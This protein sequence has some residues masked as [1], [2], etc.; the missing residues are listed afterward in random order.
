MTNP[1][2]HLLHKR[3]L[4]VFLRI[5]ISFLGFFLV[6]YFSLLLGFNYFGEKFLRKYLK[7]QITIKSEGLYNVDFNKLNLNI[8]TGKMIIREFSM[9]PDTALYR[10]MK[11]KGTISK[12][13]YQV[14]FKSLSIDHLN[15]FQIWSSRRIKLNEVV[16]EEPVVSIVGFPDTA[17]AR[18][19]R[20]RIIY[21]DIYPAVSRVCND[22][23]VDRVTVKNGLLLTSFRQKTGRLSLGEYEFSTV[24]Y[25]VSVNPFSYYN[26]ER[27]FYSRDIDFFVHN[28]EV[29]LGDSL[30]F[31]RA[32]QLGFSLN[33]SRLWGKQISLV[34]NF[35]SSRLK[36]AITGDFF[37]IEVPDFSIEG[38]DL[39]KALV[40]KEAEI[41][42]IDLENIR[43]KIFRNIKPIRDV[44]TIRRKIKLQT[45]NIY[46]II[47]G[48]LKSIAVDTFSIK[49]ASFEYFR[50]LYDLNPE[51]RIASA[52]LD[53]YHFFLDSLAHLDQN[54]IY[55]S[56]DAEL[57]LKNVS[58]KLRD[59]VHYMNSE[60]ILISTKRS[61]I[62]INNSILFPDKKLNLQSGR[63][64]NMISCLLPDL[65]FYDVDLKQVF[66]RRI[67]DFDRLE[68]SEPDITYTKYRKSRNPD[69]RFKSPENF[70]QE[71][72]EEV[73]YD[74]L[75]KYI[76]KIK[77]NSIHISHGQIRFL[78]QYEKME[79]KVFSGNFDLIMQDFIMDSI[80]GMNREGYFYSRDFTLDANELLFESPDSSRHL[81][82]DRLHVN[83][84]DSLI[85]IFDFSYNKLNNPRFIES[86]ITK[87]SSV[88]YDF[89][90]D[91][92]RVTGL[93]HKKLFLEK[94]LKAKTIVLKKP[95]LWLEKEE[96]SYPDRAPRET[97]S[98]GTSAF[99][100][101]FEIGKF[102]VQGG[103]FTYDGLD[104]QKVRYFSMDDLDFGIINAVI[105]IPERGKPD[106][107]IRFDSLQLTV[108]PVQIILADSTY[109][110]R[111]EKLRVHSYP[112]D[113]IAENIRVVPHKN[114]NND[115]KQYSLNTLVLPSLTMKGFYF[116]KAIFSNQWEMDEIRI[117]EPALVMEVRP[118]ERND[119][120]SK[121]LLQFQKIKLPPFMK[122]LDVG[123]IKMKNGSF[124]LK[125]TKRN[126]TRSYSLSNIDLI[127]DGLRIDSAAQGNRQTASLFF[128]RDV[129]FSCGG[130][131]WIT[132]DSMYT[133]SFAG[134]GFSSGARQAYVDSFTMVPN[135]SK[136]DF[137]RKI[138]HQTD[139]FVVSVPRI[140]WD[141]LDFEKLFHDQD[142]YSRRMTME[143]MT[144][145]A[146]RDKRV[147][148]PESQRPPMPARMVKMIGI[149]VTIDTVVITGG[150]VVYEEQTGEE[151][152]KVLFDRMDATLV[153]LTTDTLR[154]GQPMVFHGTSYLMGKAFFD[155]RFT[156]P[157]NT[158]NDTFSVVAY[159]NEAN[160][161]DFN[162]L[163]SKL[164]PFK[165]RSGTVTKT[166]IKQLYA[167]NNYSRGSMQMDYQN[168]NIEIQNTK[169]GLWNRWE[170]G[171][172]TLLI[173]WL[174][175]DSNPKKNGKIRVGYISYERD[176]S[177]GFFNFVWKSILSGIK[178]SLGYNSQEQ[179]EIK[180][181]DRKNQK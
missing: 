38:V 157:L 58:M 48:A 20:I 77:G 49:N 26:R 21:E 103:A 159:V 56:D 104:E 83:T 172:E 69:P 53:L 147:V 118:E 120:Q 125:L 160:L 54:K 31:L 158:P 52:N 6:V 117:E 28:L 170:T 173:N 96:K 15:F 177:K 42:D 140:Q 30:Y 45:A 151:P 111:C 154:Q 51:I 14:Y 8:L 162:P 150:G 155:A 95:G 84:E 17:T 119:N 88:V 179:K 166:E 89:T 163:V 41:K 55:Y 100:R 34:P 136:F 74:L 73:V 168:I 57:Q 146:Y 113:I 102:T 130:Q 76:E 19:S 18:R 65:V 80:H 24:L 78:R 126:T 68:I 61:L 33:K 161:T 81:E 174:I 129:T 112:A 94:I 110:L 164:L 1:E 175:P 167:N 107:L 72:N 131:K 109:V 180:K 181:A 90:F 62:N 122:S 75:Q 79:K 86:R 121:D 12:A 11:D 141:Y 10:K 134:F 16:F 59:E 46:T 137:S 71:E 139:R 92:L 114:S 50:N 5:L 47:A 108:F 152:G 40:G 60:E 123:K 4:S 93:N 116:D 143:R 64:I 171:L 142:I 87:R 27:V 144:I 97:I 133:Y 135:F 23:H 37:Q 13:L 32:D 29:S 178:S 153:N 101:S 66:N 128:C 25:D 148:F 39:Y 132:N 169:P 165:I 63:P 70:F 67:I 35:N 9:L 106:G 99:P 2:N 138:G 176:K 3:R 43:F 36:S 127:A 145:E 22:F 115:Q 124:D 105:H 98:P 44:T 149:P 7:E 82:V 85:E 156:I 91:E